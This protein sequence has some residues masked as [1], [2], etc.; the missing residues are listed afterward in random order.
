MFI[1]NKIIES[2]QIHGFMINEKNISLRHVLL[3]NYRR[4]CLWRF[5]LHN[6]Q[7]IYGRSSKQGIIKTSSMKNRYKIFY[8]ISMTLK[9]KSFLFYIKYS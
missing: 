7:V 4:T 8:K 3:V 9:N 6:A 5:S 2:E 1:N